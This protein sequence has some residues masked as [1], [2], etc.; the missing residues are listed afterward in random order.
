LEEL[1]AKFKHLPNVTSPLIKRHTKLHWDDC[2][3]IR[4]ELREMRAREVVQPPKRKKW[5]R[6][7]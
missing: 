2:D 5:E 1:H 3:E 7:R 4:D 6:I